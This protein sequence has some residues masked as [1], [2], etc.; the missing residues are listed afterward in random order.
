[1]KK[2]EPGETGLGNKEPI[3]ALR[4]LVVEDQADMRTGL[5]VLF[6]F[7]GCRARFAVDLASARL[8]AREERFDVLL[9]DINLPDGDGWDLLRELAAAGRRPPAAI[10]MS[11][12]GSHN[13][14]ARSRAAGF[15][16]HLVKPFAPEELT[17]I[18][19]RVAEALPD[20]ESRISSTPRKRKLAH[21]RLDGGAPPM[22]YPCL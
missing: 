16:T 2:T 20:K 14:L 18:L 15:D 22:I 12:F 1:V 13:D 17:A 5:A 4:L 10:A 3:K 8:A 6:K 7:L 21:V 11:G 19:Q 9:S